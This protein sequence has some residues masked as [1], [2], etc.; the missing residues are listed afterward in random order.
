MFKNVFSVTSIIICL[1]CVVIAGCGEPLPALKIQPGEKIA[2]L[3]VQDLH[4]NKAKLAT[5]TGKVLIVNVWATWCGPCR[6]EM[7]SL[8]R[9]SNILDQ[10][11]FQVIGVSVD[12]DDHVVREFLI[13]RKVSFVN[14][15]DPGM[16]IAND[17]LG[18]R[19][20]PST[21]IIGPRGNLLK[22]IE[23]WREWDSKHM[24]TD[25]RKFAS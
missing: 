19:A 15:M 23:G 17:L 2:D 18:L 12:T 3:A 4:G 10:E 13:E 20:F 5:Q 21:F 22:V 16:A 11:R 8:D 14:Y 25:I 1:L 7:P 24:V 6:H 9:L